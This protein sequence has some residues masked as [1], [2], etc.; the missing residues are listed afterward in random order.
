MKEK[1]K[2]FFIE[3]KE[4][5]IFIGVVVF[6]FASVIGIASLALNSNE[7]VDDTPPVTE[8]PDNNDDDQSTDVETPDDTTPVVVDKFILPV[9]GDYVMVRTF[10][11]DSLSLEELESAVIVNGSDMITSTGISYAKEDNNTFDVLAIYDGKV[12]SVTEDELCGAT[13]EIEHDNKIVSV[14]SS[15]QDVKVKAGDVVEQGMVIAK[16]STS[17]N[18]TKAGVHVH[19]QVKSDN[20]YLNPTSIYGKE[21][22]EVADLK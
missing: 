16:A 6:V 2:R 9:T 10:F 14:Y 5:L 21:I 7:N 22:A 8:T 19:L 1:I 15:L 3:K 13:I 20:K 12:V 18:D 4:L 17:I 11:D